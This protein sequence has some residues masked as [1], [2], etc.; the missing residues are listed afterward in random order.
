MV[1]ELIKH[2]GLDGM[3]LF[4]IILNNEVLIK[5]F[6]GIFA[7]DQL[8]FDIPE[9]NIYYIC[10]TDVYKNEGKHWIVIYKKEKSNVIEFFDSLGKKPN[11]RF[12]N[13]M[14]KRHICY[15][16]KRVQGYLTNTC[17]YHCIYFLCRR[18]KGDNFEIIM[19][20]YDSS[21]EINDKFVIDFVKTKFDT[22]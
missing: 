19:N 22:A 3:R 8:T 18:M 5:Y 7:I 6:G 15:N 20:G 1:M 16:K 9:K 11:E 4:E 12:I 21:Y 13:F 14:K 17:A 10:N 2:R